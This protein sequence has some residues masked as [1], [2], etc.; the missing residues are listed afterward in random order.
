METIMTINYY[1]VAKI[2]HSQPSNVV[3]KPILRYKILSLMSARNECKQAGWLLRL[4]LYIFAN[5]VAPPVL[6]YAKI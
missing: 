5:L 4:A 2:K 3:I 1:C 6:F